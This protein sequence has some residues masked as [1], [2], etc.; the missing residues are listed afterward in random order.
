MT[1]KSAV[2]TSPALAPFK[3][4]HHPARFYYTPPKSLEAV[5][6]LGSKI[7]KVDVR[8]LPK[9]L[10][11]NCETYGETYGDKH[12]DLIDRVINIGRLTAT[13]VI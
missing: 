8:D 13:N 12:A 10:E 5:I 9:A 1:P 3:V 6:T 11:S 7:V 4:S 2:D